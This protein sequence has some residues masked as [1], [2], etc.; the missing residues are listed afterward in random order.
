[1]KKDRIYKAKKRQGESLEKQ[2]EICEKENNATAKRRQGESFEKQKER[3]EKDQ[4]TSTKICASKV[5][6][7]N[8]KKASDSQKIY[9]SKTFD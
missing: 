8:T 5:T 3:R 2:Q 7:V 6:Q 9:G 1:M 4:I